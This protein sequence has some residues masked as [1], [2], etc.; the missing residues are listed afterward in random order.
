MVFIGVASMNSKIILSLLITLLFSTPAFAQDSG[1]AGLTDREIQLLYGEF[2]KVRTFGL[3]AVS[4]VGDAE[5]IGLDSRSIKKY[6][7]EQFK[8]DF[9]KVTYQDLTDDPRRF[10]KLLAAQDPKIG[11][12]SFRIW[13]V[14]GSSVLAYHVRCD[15]GSFRNLSIWSEEVLG[16]GTQATA[17]Q[18]I[19]E[20]IAEMMHQLAIN[21]FKARGQKCD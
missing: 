2:K 21:F 3:I 18:T 8:K 4:L 16:H 19:N 9:C 5:R 1:P 14:G 10:A 17:A 12:I 11:T 15:A 13:V 6:I 20:I 7:Q